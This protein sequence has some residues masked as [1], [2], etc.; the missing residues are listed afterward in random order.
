[1][2]RVVEA[3]RARQNTQGVAVYK[4]EMECWCLSCM[5]LR[6]VYGRCTFAK[7]MDLG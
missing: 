4:G 1:M 2:I 5:R 7:G 3:T 6:T